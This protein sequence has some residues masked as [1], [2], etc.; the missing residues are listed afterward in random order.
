MCCA[1]KE[2]RS[3][4]ALLANRLEAMVRERRAFDKTRRRAFARPRE[5]LD[6]KWTPPKSRNELHER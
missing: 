5:G 6:L 1:A 4:S 3:L 2:G